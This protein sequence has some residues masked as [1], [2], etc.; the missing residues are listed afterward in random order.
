M[1]EPTAEDQADSLVAREGLG[2]ALFDSSPDCIKIISL[3]GVL[4]AM[5]VN[6]QHCLEI[7]DIN[8]FCGNHWSTMWPPQERAKV[9]AAIADART[10][11]IGR[12]T[13]FCPT[14]KGTPK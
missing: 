8:A 6:G 7:D 4:E 10:N 11:R 9:V 14:A 2:R 3:D 13:A 5:N 1:S 12:F